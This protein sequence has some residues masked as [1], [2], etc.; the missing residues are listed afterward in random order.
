M[1]NEDDGKVTEKMRMM[2]GWKWLMNG[3]MMDGMNEEIVEHET[4]MV[5]EIMDGKHEATNLASRL[6]I[7]M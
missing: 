5:D 6:L 3:K 2:V 1:K 4:D 7:T